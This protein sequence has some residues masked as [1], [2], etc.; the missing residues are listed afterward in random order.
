MSAIALAYSA[1]ND[2]A[3]GAG[4]GAALGL[5]ISVDDACTA[6]IG[7]AVTA[8][9][10]TETEARFDKAQHAKTSNQRDFMGVPLRLKAGGR[11]AAAIPSLL[12]GAGSSSD[13]RGVNGAAGFGGDRGSATAVIFAAST[14]G[15]TISTSLLLDCDTVTS[16]LASAGPC[17]TCHV[18]E[19]AAASQEQF[20][21]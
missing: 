8:A 7:A 4:A 18:S 19:M 21:A 17:I 15:A 9:A 3:T 5:S 16:A 20:V 12:L 1:S 14:T 11:P 13:T 2:V 10:S 6:S